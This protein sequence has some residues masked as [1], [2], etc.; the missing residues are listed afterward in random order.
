MALR[1]RHRELGASFRDDTKGYVAMV[2]R[3]LEALSSA[4]E[5]KG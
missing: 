3:Y 2:E 4:E 1:S 5:R